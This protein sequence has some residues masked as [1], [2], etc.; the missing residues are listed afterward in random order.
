MS[1][2]TT[3]WA[4]L[5]SVMTAEDERRPV[6]RD[7]LRRIGAFARPHRRELILFLLLGTATAALAVATPCSPGGW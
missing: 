6:T 4:Q 3:A 7:T 2:E 5:R 1:M